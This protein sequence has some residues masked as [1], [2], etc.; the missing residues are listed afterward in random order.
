[1]T[2]IRFIKFFGIALLVQFFFL[3]GGY[4]LLFGPSGEKHF[5]DSMLFYVY[6][7]FIELIIR[8][9]GYTGES[10]MIWPPVFGIMLGIF[11]YSGLFA[12]IVVYLTRKK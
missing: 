4:T 7:P 6:S 10:S 5:R 12:V 9:G 3:L 2:P 1:M 11:I 8:M